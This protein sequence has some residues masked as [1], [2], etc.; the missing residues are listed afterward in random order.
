[1]NKKEIQRRVCKI[2]ECAK[3]KHQ[4]NNLSGNY[5]MTN[6]QSQFKIALY[7]YAHSCIHESIK[8]PSH[9]TEWNGNTI[10]VKHTLYEQHL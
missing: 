5:K 4:Y 1:M 2:I 6:I 3:I 9:Y 10:V 7:M 8:C